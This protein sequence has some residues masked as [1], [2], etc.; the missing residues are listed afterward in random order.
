MNYEYRQL[1]TQ[2]QMHYA[3]QTEKSL[4]AMILLFLDLT[5]KGQNTRTENRP[6]PAP[7]RLGWEIRSQDAEYVT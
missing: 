6:L 2:V 7:T 5:E 4:H 1:Y 3:S